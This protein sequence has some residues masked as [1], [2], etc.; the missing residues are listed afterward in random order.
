MRIWTASVL[1][2]LFSFSPAFAFADQPPTD[3]SLRELLDVMQAHKIVDSIIAQSD[4]VGRT[5]VQQALNG[6]SL[7]P[8][9][10]KILDTQLD[11]VHGVILN[12]LSWEKISPMYMDIYRN[13]FTQKEVD[14]MIAFYKSPT[15]QAVIQKLPVVMQQ[16]MVQMKSHIAV[17][18]PQIQQINQDTVSQMQAYES[19]KKGQGASK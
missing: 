19:S 15:G 18:M 10:Q 3:S 1:L 2:F 12:E 5:A 8:Q 16:S 11:K 14:G 7:D 17:I 6:R 9:E 4:A 13:S